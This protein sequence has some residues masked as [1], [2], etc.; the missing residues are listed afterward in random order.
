MSGPT[1]FVQKHENEIPG[2]FQDNSRTFFS[3]QGLNFIDF[4]SIFDCFCR[5]RRFGNSSHFISITGIF[6]LPEY[7]L[8]NTG[9]T[10]KLNRSTVPPSLFKESSN[11]HTVFFRT[12]HK[13]KRM[14]KNQCILLFSKTNSRAI[15]QNSRTIPGLMA[16]F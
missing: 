4:Q 14:E 5:K 15:L 3:F 16:L 2:L 12:S 6:S 1:G 8:I 10:G 13:S 11:F 7:L 9:T